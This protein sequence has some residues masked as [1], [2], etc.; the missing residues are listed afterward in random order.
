[1]CYFYIYTD[2]QVYIILYHK[3]TIMCFLKVFKHAYGKC[4]E[5]KCGNFHN[6][7]IIVYPLESA[8][9]TAQLIESF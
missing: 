8:I 4:A 5:P 3:L 6:I 1:M 2:T 7:I 9:T